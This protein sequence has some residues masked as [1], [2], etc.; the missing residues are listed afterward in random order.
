M[1]CVCVS[2][3]SFFWWKIYSETISYIH[4]IW[5][6]GRSCS[7]YRNFHF[8]HI[9][10]IIRCILSSESPSSCLHIRRTWDMFEYS[11][12]QHYIVHT[13]R[14][15]TSTIRKKKYGIICDRTLR[16]PSDRSSQ[17]QKTYKWNYSHRSHVNNWTG[18][19]MKLQNAAVYFIEIINICIIT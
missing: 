11:T 1:F 10:F 3:W 9:L 19:E 6:T 7:F 15:K 17:Q 18:D 12:Q 16:F 14:Q 8:S 2:M 13:I 5:K 4:H